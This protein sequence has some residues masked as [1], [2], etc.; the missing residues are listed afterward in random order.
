MS[1]C[2]DPLEV[3]VDFHFKLGHRKIEKEMIQDEIA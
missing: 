1:V 2:R 3:Y